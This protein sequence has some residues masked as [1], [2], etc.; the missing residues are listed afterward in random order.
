MIW[1]DPLLDATE[2]R[3]NGIHHKLLSSR[4]VRLRSRLSLITVPF[5]LSII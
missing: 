1:L 5:H 2:S 3:R 4:R